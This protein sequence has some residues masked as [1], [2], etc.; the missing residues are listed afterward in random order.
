LS[1]G[2][3]QLATGNWQLAIGNWQLAIG[4]WQLAIGNWQLAIGNSQLAGSVSTVRFVAAAWPW[5]IPFHPVRVLIDPLSSRHLL[6]CCCS[7]HGRLYRMSLDT[8]DVVCVLPADTFHFWYLNGV[9]QAP[10]EL[11]RDGDAL[12]LLL[13]DMRTTC[14]SSEGKGR[15]WLSGFADRRNRRACVGV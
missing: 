7:E 8:G 15:P 6:L 5:E 4:N 1:I 11:W 3:W 10:A 9:A 2:N 14:R 13:G 12:A